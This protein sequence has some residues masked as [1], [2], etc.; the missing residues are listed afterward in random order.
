[1]GNVRRGLIGLVLVVG[2]LLSGCSGNLGAASAGVAAP[3]QQVVRVDDFQDLPA[4]ITP[5]ELA[6]LIAEAEITV[7]DVRED[8]EFADGHIPGAVHIPLGSL[9]ARVDEVPADVP[10]V[11]VC[12]SGNRS[13]E[14]YRLLSQEGFDNI[15]NMVGGM[16]D[17]A[18]AGL[19]VTR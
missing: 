2:V 14:A 5:E 1:M 13:A 8:W 19:D 7:I 12:R 18:A 6:D 17:W 15:S 16:K 3:A 4:E 11:L 9:S 10:V